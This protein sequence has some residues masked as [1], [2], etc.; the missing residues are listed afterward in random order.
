MLTRGSKLEI[1]IPSASTTTREW[2]YAV[3]FPD[4]GNLKET[5]D[6]VTRSLCA[7]ALRR[8]AGNR[9]DAAALLGI[10]RQSLYRYMGKLDSAESASSHSG[11]ADQ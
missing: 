9:Q 4:K 1:E 11:Y 3:G 6:D 2:S 10:S 5:V 8:A 7:E